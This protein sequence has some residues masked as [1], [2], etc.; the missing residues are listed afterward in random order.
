MKKLNITII[1][2]LSVE[3]RPA[4]KTEVK[5][6]AAM[7]NYLRQ[8]RDGITDEDLKVGIQALVYTEDG[9]E[10]KNIMFRRNSKGK[11]E[12]PNSI[13]E[14]CRRQV[15]KARKAAKEKAEKEAA[16]K[17]RKAEANRRYRARKKAEKEALKASSNKS[18]ETTAETVKA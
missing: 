12:M 14:T 6:E 2:T 8:V 18:V 7:W 11:I 4:I 5:S 3:K 9:T 17:A 10:F 16:R 13:K 15:E 1:T